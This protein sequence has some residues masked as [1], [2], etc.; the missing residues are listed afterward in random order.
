[1]AVDLLLSRIKSVIQVALEDRASEK[2]DVEWDCSVIP[3]QIEGEFG[4][5]LVIYISL[6]RYDDQECGIDTNIYQFL[7][8]D[9][10]TSDFLV[11]WVDQTWDALVLRGLEVSLD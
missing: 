2:D 3:S 7:P 8:L 1:M 10:C 9:V 11:Q 6:S 4:P 5:S